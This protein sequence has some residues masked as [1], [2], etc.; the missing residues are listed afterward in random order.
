MKS[1][2]SFA[3]ETIGACLSFAISTPTVSDLDGDAGSSSDNL[4]GSAI[5]AASRGRSA[6]AD[7]PNLSTPRASAA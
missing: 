6:T 4:A 1:P 5:S 2:T 3:A 7:E